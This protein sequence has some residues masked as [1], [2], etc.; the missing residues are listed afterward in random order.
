MRVCLPISLLLTMILAS[1]PL[2]AAHSQSWSPIERWDVNRVLSQLGEGETITV[3][4]RRVDDGAQM[5]TVE[6]ISE[7]RAFASNCAIRDLGIRNSP[8]RSTAK[9]NF[10]CDPA[11]RY[12]LALAFVDAKLSEIELHPDG[13]RFIPAVIPSIRAIPARPSRLNA[14]PDS[15][16]V[17]FLHRLLVIRVLEGGGSFDQLLANTSNEVALI[18]PR[19][20]GTTHTQIGLSFLEDFYRQITDNGTFQLSGKCVD[21]AIEVVAISKAK[22][23]IALLSAQMVMVGATII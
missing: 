21:V 17:V 1:L 6:E 5:V 23:W 20:D 19:E 2:R 22:S 7:L 18:F 8:G 14:D 11:T 9:F 12:G 4:V 16:E 10:D 13:V 3:P 15:L